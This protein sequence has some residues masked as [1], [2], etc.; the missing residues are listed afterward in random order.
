MVVC[1]RCSATVPAHHAVTFQGPTPEVVC[2]ACVEMMQRE[3]PAFA[4]EL[5][6]EPEVDALVASIAL[7]LGEVA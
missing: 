2:L 1:S 7:S 6:S 5:D 3:V 4:W